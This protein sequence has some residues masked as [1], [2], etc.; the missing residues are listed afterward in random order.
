MT[1]NKLDIVNI[2][3]N[4]ISPPSKCCYL[5]QEIQYKRNAEYLQKKKEGR[6][7]LILCDPK[8]SFIF[9]LRAQRLSPPFTQLYSLPVDDSF[10]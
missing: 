10:G 8:T 6:E 9:L 4:E 2:K 7:M 5:Y 3:E 1:K